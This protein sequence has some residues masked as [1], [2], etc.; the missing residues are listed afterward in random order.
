MYPHTNVNAFD[1]ILTGSMWHCRG[2]W[3]WTVWMF[4]A[5]PLKAAL[6]KQMGKLTWSHLSVTVI[7]IN[8]INP[9]TIL[10]LVHSLVI[11]L[12]KRCLTFKWPKVRR[13]QQLHASNV[14]DRRPRCTAWRQKKKKKL[15]SRARSFYSQDSQVIGV[16]SFRLAYFR[17]FINRHT[18]TRRA[19]RHTRPCAVH[20]FCHVTAAQVA[21]WLEFG[22]NATK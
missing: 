9:L 8:I 19:R 3:I 15:L 21:D 17:C 16:T 20:R 1:Q 12:L 2:D 5:C 7:L 6:K 11:K 13:H 14:R 4:V 10:N 18:Y 22:D